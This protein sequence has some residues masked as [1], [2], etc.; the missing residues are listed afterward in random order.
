MDQNVRSQILAELLDRLGDEEQFARV[1]ARANVP[2]IILPGQSLARHYEQVIDR[3]WQNGADALIAYLDAASV[4]AGGGFDVRATLRK[5]SSSGWDVAEMR[6]AM[7][8][9]PPK[10]LL[11]AAL[12]ADAGSSAAGAGTPSGSSP[13]E[14]G[15]SP[16][17]AARGLEPVPVPEIDAL[18]R[19]RA[20]REESIRP[21]PVGELDRTVEIPSLTERLK[22]M[23]ADMGSMVDRLALGG[24]VP[25]GSALKL[26]EARLVANVAGDGTRGGLHLVGE[27]FSAPLFLEI[28]GLPGTRLVERVR[29]LEAYAMLTE[30][31]R[32]ELMTRR[33]RVIREGVA[34][35]WAPV[36]PGGHEHMGDP[37][38]A[39]RPDVAYVPA[40]EYQLPGEPGLRRLER[41]ILLGLTAVTN[42]EMIAFVQKT[43]YV[44]ELSEEFL[45]HYR[46]ENVPD[47]F[48][49][50]PAIFV[51]QADAEAYCRWVGGMLPT[52][53]MWERAAVGLTAR[54]YPWGDDF[55]QNRLNSR[56]SRHG[57][58]MP[59][60][61]FPEGRGEYGHFNLAGNVWEWTSSPGPDADH[62]LLKGGAWVNDR[63][64]AGNG[65]R[66]VHRRE[67]RGFYIGFRVAFEVPPGILM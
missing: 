29:P 40:G 28:D 7:I 41:S 27:G 34:S 47:Q 61:S 16:A 32:V 3:L 35:A 20:R 67:L 52:V 53:E 62:A 59:V 23:A 66:A 44:P 64:C 24:I 49:D 13:V 5:R 33:I 54:A 25:G 57:W 26:R 22:E 43:G 36:L 48:W 51:N 60:R 58:T 6:T 21:P 30:R 4:E 2:I 63:R 12:A 17:D 10:E 42:R 39:L 55:D 37:W 45:K 46:A 8:M 11:D 50:R 15:T 9:L 19:N 14:A 18:E 31:D 1:A 56:E 38:P 65:Y